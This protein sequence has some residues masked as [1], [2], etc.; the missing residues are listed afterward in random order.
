MYIGNKDEWAKQSILE[1]ASVGLEGEYF[2]SDPECTFTI[3]TVAMK[4]YTDSETTVEPQHLLDICHV[5]Y[6]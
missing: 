6:H 1:L 2:T 5:S 4:L 3:Q